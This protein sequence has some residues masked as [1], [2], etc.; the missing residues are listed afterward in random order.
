M[1]IRGKGER[2]KY[3]P[4]APTKR[5]GQIDPRAFAYIRGGSAQDRADN[6]FA[7]LAFCGWD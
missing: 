4:R 1:T 7:R 2:Y 3:P 5:F 6:R